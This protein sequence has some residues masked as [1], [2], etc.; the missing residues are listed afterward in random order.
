VIKKPSVYMNCLAIFDDVYS[1]AKIIDFVD[2]K[3]VK[4]FFVDIGRTCVYG[5]DEII[6]T[7]K[8]IVEIQPYMVI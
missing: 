1:R 4:I 5:V 6:K 8:E 7:T 2:E 3:T